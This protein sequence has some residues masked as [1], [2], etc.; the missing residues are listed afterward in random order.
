MDKFVSYFKSKLGSSETSL[1]FLSIMIMV[2]NALIVVGFWGKTAYETLIILRSIHFAIGFGCLIAIYKLRRKWND[3]IAKF[4]F[5]IILVP[6]FFIAW[7]NHSAMIRSDESWIPFK[8]F[9]IIILGLT[10]VTPVGYLINFY[11][12]L[13]FVFEI[14]LIWFILD[15][16]LHQNLILSGEPYYILGT[17]FICLLLLISRY[18]DEKKLKFL[19]AENAKVEFAKS[20]ARVLLT[21]RD[22]MNTPLQN[23]SLLLHLLKNSQHLPENK[24]G[25]LENALTDLIVTNRQ[26]NRLET[27]V[28]WQGNNLMSDEEIETWLNS[29]GQKKDILE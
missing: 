27:L 9:Y 3:K 25:A 24:A 23:L 21:I 20:L 12:L 16:P 14:V 26:F 13:A 18:Q 10:V 29:L 19:A 6:L 5:C 28:D 11:L 17:S 1:I 8:G 22:R 7:T 2:F 15:I 4:I